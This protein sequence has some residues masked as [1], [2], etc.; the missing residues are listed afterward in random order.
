MLKIKV[1]IAVNFFIL[2]SA[3]Q[4]PALLRTRGAY[5]STTVPIAS[6]QPAALQRRIPGDTRHEF[7]WSI[8]LVFARPSGEFRIAQTPVHSI[9]ILRRGRPRASLCRRGRVPAAAKI[10]IAD[11]H[12]VVRR[13]LR[14]L[15]ASPRHWNV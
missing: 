7:V 5:E 11:G 8:R 6:R 1:I 9:S 13:S 2:P 10:L 4:L 14:S 3:P 12:E 15:L